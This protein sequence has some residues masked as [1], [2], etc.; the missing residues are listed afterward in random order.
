MTDLLPVEEVRSRVL[1][2]VP[3]MPAEEVGYLESLGRVLADPV[4]AA[5][6]VPP[7]PNSAMDGYAV[8]SDDVSEPGAVLEVVGEVGAGAVAAVPVGEGQA[9][10]IMTGAPMPD[11][12]DTVVRVEDTEEEAGKVHLM[13][14]VPPATSVRP[15]GGDVT[16]GQEV[17]GVG[18]RITPVDVGMMATVGVVRP[19]V[20]RQP[21]V[22][23]MSTGDE[24]QPPESASLSPGA[25]R[26][27]NRPMLRGLI[28]EAGA[29]P[30]D[31]GRVSDDPADLRAAIADAADRADAIVTSGGVS[32]GERDVTKLVLGDGAGVEFV[33]VAMK[34]AKPF[35]FGSVHGVPFFGLPGNPVSVFVSFEQFARPFLLAMQGARALFRPAVEGT[36]GERIET[37]PAKAVFVRVRLHEEEGRLVARS[38]GGQGSN[39]LSAMAS[40]DA[41][42]VVPV[43]VGVVETGDRVR[44]E[45]FRA[46]EARWVEGGD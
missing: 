36:A 38:A 13:V 28:E 19:V 41:L 12:A 40:A 15:A 17:L 31:L 30:W 6:D 8:R 3:L 29:V 45:L 27:S 44:L 34:P 22:A 18:T 33:Q 16:V 39:I 20:S 4:T 37:D 25:I 2:A 24:L 26:D 43:G 14:A 42:A 21:R 46:P 7:F 1:S 9:I 23:L 35:A 5:E 32:M 10:R 11:G